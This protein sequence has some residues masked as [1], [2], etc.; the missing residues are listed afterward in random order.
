MGLVLVIAAIL[1]MTITIGISYDRNFG[2]REF[3][4]HAPFAPFGS[5]WDP[6][7]PF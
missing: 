2:Y 3:G 7:N 5:D 4:I 1:H 6:L